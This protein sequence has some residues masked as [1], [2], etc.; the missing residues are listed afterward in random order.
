VRIVEVYH[1]VEG[2][3][4][5]PSSQRMPPNLTETDR[6][7]RM[8]RN[9]ENVR[10]CAGM[11]DYSR[12]TV[13]LGSYIP[14]VS[15]LFVS[16]EQKVRNI[17]ARFPLSFRPNRDILHLSVRFCSNDGNVTECGR[18]GRNGSNPRELP[19]VSAPFIRN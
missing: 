1:P 19:P 5:L 13:G 11:W 16:F 17:P 9:V 3:C 15:H 10:E 8:L 7:V 14:S 12:F 2:K 18:F 6:K 4:L